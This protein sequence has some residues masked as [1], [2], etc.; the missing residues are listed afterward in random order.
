VTP[1]LVV[2]AAGVG[3]R[4]GG[5]KQ[6]EPVGPG[7]AALMDYA[8]YDA[9]RSG[10]G[11]V[12]LVI[13]RD[14]EGEI[15]DHVE[16]GAARRIEVAYALQELHSLPEGFAVP[17]NRSKPWGTGQAVLA[18]S[19]HLDRPFVVANADDFYGRSAIAALAAHLGL[20][21]GGGQPE[22]AMVGYRL[23][24]TLPESG[25]V[26]RAL[27]VQDDSGALVALREVVAIERADGGARWV[28]GDGIRRTEPLDRL[29][30][31]NLWGFTPELVAHLER[32]FRAFLEAG[33][34]P[35]DEYYL[36]VAVGEAVAGGAARVTVLD[37]GGRWC[38]MTSPGD[39]AATAAVLRQ[40]VDAG[41]Y[42]EKLWE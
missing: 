2:L 14:T 36:P 24:D 8:I 31:M 12:V 35:K 3:S 30:S 23:G 16:A 25:A 27:C 22:W 39:R 5:L 10:F 38:G 7:G 4:Y 17:A 32:G 34:R 13:R 20:A 21:G 15:R 37:A 28:D 26:S 40:L 18:A 42:P 1:T 11:K 9:V 19:E 33:P 6:L 41:E 29:V